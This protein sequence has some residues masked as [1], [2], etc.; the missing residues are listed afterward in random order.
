MSQAPSLASVD[1]SPSETQPVLLEK[2][3][4]TR[5]LVPKSELP[6]SVKVS[7]TELFTEETAF[8]NQPPPSAAKVAGTQAEVIKTK[9]AKVR[10]KILDFFELVQVVIVSPLFN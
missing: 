9:S 6:N 2:W 1:K 5:G 4:L 3:G 8:E 7:F 10:L